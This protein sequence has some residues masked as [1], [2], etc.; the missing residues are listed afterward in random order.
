M[1]REAS[2]QLVY[3]LSMLIHKFLNFPAIELAYQ[4]Q[5][6]GVPTARW[7]IILALQCISALLSAYATLSFPIQVAETRSLKERCS[8]CSF[9]RNFC[10]LSKRMFQLVNH[11][12]ITYITIFL[13]MKSDRF[14]YFRNVVSGTIRESNFESYSF[15]IYGSIIFLVFPLLVLLENLLAVTILLAGKG[16]KKA[17]EII[18]RFE[19]MLRIKFEK[20]TRLLTITL[21]ARRLGARSRSSLFFAFF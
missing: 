19:K 6:Q 4:D 13:V 5:T 3:Q 8:Y 2:V 15:V 9:W 18:S 20:F 17:Q 11:I 16:R 12:C 14:E 7:S 10:M 1:N 21:G